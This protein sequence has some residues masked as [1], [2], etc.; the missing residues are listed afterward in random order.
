VT[1]QP[2]RWRSAL[3]VGKVPKSLGKCPFS[4]ESAH[5]VGEVPIF[6]DEGMGVWSVM[7]RLDLGPVKK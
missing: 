4:W 6:H 7:V 5:S 2:K 1:L 3:F